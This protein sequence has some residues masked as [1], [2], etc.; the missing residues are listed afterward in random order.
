MEKR[1]QQENVGRKVICE[2]LD[3]GLLGDFF[4]S[5]EKYNRY[6]IQIVKVIAVKFLLRFWL[7]N[8]CKNFV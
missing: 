8:F 2:F 7:P 1:V 5:P 6:C 4:P 3:V